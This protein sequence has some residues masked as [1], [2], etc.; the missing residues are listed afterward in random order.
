M[1]MYDEKG[2][3]NVGIGFAVRTYRSPRMGFDGAV[4]QSLD[5]TWSTVTMTVKGF[6]LLFH[7]INIR[8]AVAGPLKITQLIGE[9]ATSGFQVGIA[10][11]IINFF[12]LLALLS[13]VLLLMNLLPIPATDGGQIII[14]IVE[15]ARGK[16][17]RSRLIWRL[18]I[19]GFSALLMIFV[20]VSFSDILSFMGR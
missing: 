3:P 2:N 20:L 13:V 4:R 11:G 1:L 6:G 7:G 8:K 18:Q 12:R 17:L 14:F 16:P 5:E 15:M 19:I 9:A 10:F